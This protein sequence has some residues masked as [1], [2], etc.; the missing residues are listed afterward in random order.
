MNSH[1]YGE[2]PAPEPA[3]SLAPAGGSM[4][5][6]RLQY[7]DWLYRSFPW[8]LMLAG[9]LSIVQLHSA[10]TVPCGLL[11]MY[12]GTHFLIRRDRYRTAFSQSSGWMSV[13]KWSLAGTPA[14]GT[15]QVSWRSS[16]DFGYPVLD[17][18]HRRMFGLC[19]ELLKVASAK[20][21][22]ERVKLL[23]TQ[24]LQHMEEHLHTE[25]AVLAGMKEDTFT[26]HH[27]Q[28]IVLLDRARHLLVRMQSGEAVGR[29]LI[30][31]VTYNLVVLHLLKEVPKPAK[32]GKRALFERRQLRRHRVLTSLDRG[33]LSGARLEL[34][35]QDECSRRLR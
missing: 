20:G 1:S 23:F 2:A 30:S 4:N 14:A 16:F 10:L 18:Q 21:S 33:R 32:V 22:R 3:R 7:P 8:L 26:A 19:S 9:A 28:Y 11:L 34:A 29:A 25:A 12:A 24:L 27:A 5:S 6:R 31:F 35:V 13:P 15:V 17:A